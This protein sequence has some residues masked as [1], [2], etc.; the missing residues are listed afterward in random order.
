MKGDGWP[1]A[2]LATH[3]N[4]APAH[5]M[6]PAG[7]QCFHAGFLRGETSGVAFNAVCL[8]V[9]ILNLAVG[10]NTPDETLSK[11]GDGLRNARH[12]RN[13][14]TSSDDHEWQVYS[15]RSPR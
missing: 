14:D 15:R 2:G 4:V 1:A 10:E 7:A 8:G 12:F 5:A 11:T 3:F 9:A 13:V 6:I